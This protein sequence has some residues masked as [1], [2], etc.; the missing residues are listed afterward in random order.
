LR[1]F[2]IQKRGQA[3][4]PLSPELFVTIEPFERVA[5]RLG[6]E[7]AGNGASG[8][9][10][11]DQAGVRQDIQMFHDRRQRHRKRRGKLGHR[12]I[13]LPG[14]PHHQRPP[15]RIGKRGKGAV[16]SGV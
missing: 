11:F 7:T 9:G 3:I 2:F 1:L 14:K 10:A 4:E 6:F 5:H 16:E 8:F 15:G 13:R 12:N